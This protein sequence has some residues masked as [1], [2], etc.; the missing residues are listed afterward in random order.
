[1]ETRTSFTFELSEFQQ[2]ALISLLESGNYRPATVPYAIMAAD[3]KVVALG[4][5]VSQDDTRILADAG[6]DGQKNAT[7]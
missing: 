5:V 6:E 4:N 7:L 2:A 3:A 1:M